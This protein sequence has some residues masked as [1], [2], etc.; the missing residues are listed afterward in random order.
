MLIALIRQ[1]LSDNAWFSDSVMILYFISLLI[2]FTFGAHGFVMVY[3]YLRQRKM[4][5]VPP[6]GRN[7]HGHGTAP[8]LQ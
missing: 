3:H 2:L 5:D 7:P 8:D 1:E 6:D 4:K